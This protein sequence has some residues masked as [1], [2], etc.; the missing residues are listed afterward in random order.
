M[1]LSPAPVP[2]ELYKLS[3]LYFLQLLENNLSGT[4]SAHIQQLTNLSMLNFASNYLE[5]PLPA[6]IFEMGM[7]TVVVAYNLLSGRLPTEVGL[8]KGTNLGLV[9]NLLTG[10]LPEELFFAPNLSKISLGDNNVSAHQVY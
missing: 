8:F 6:D 1:I 4:I 10:S 7:A 9:G 3:S 5:G 2:I